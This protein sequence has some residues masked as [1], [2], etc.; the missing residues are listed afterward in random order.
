[1][2]GRTQ[3][4]DDSE[5]FSQKQ[6]SRISDLLGRLPD[7]RAIRKTHLF[8]NERLYQSGDKDPNLYLIETGRIKTVTV[9]L[10]GKECLLSIQT[11]GDL[12]GESCLVQAE[13]AETAIA[14]GPSAVR[15]IPR[16]AFLEML[17][18]RDLMEPCL[19]YLSRRLF[20]QQQLITHLVT[21]D[22]RQ[23]LAMILLE[24][25][26]KLGASDG[27]SVRIEQKITHEELGA[28]VGTT[29]SRIGY[30]LKSFRDMGLIESVPDAFV[31]INQFRML[32]YL[33]ASIA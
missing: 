25:G 20:E 22:S 5:G 14:M 28:M 10:A 11:Q 27:G 23:R 21:E 7:S 16:M 31:V 19:Y 33:A 13:R 6:P 1:M 29:R 4:P 15:I 9:S 26:Y 30:F 8:R 32:E 18:D 3:W 17:S 2:M 12:V 24:L